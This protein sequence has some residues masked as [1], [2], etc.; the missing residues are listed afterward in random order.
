MREAGE[1]GRQ[2]SAGGWE[3][4]EAGALEPEVLLG[5]AVTNSMDTRLLAFVEECLLHGE[6]DEIRVRAHVA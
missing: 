5:T 1:C 3:R 2:G 6:S 4:W